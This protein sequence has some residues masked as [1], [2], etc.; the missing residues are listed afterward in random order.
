MRLSPRFSLSAF[1]FLLATGAVALL[2]NSPIPVV[3]LPYGSFQGKILGVTT[4]FL[5]MPYAAPPYVLRRVHIPP[6]SQYSLSVA[7]A[8]ASV[9]LVCQNPPYHS[10]KF[11]MLLLLGHLVLS[12]SGEFH[13]P[14]QSHFPPF[15]M[16]QKTV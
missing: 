16:I 15:Q 11:V 2:D 14:F 8:L 4:Q 3:T 12:K 5:G 1:A 10:L 13:Q 7:T 9:A 6:C